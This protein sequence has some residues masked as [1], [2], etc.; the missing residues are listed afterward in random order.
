[1]KKLPTLHILNGDA[2]LP[3]I[4]AAKL[5]G[6]ILVWR[7]ILSEGPAIAGLPEEVFWQRRQMYMEETYGETAATYKLNVLDEL[8]KLEAAGSFF[9]VVLWFDADL[10]CQ[11]NLLYLLH[12]MHQLKPATVYVCTPPMPENISLLKKETLLN[13]YE[14]RQNQTIQQLKQAHDL[15]QLYAGTDPMAVQRYLQ[16]HQ[17]TV[18][19]HF[20]NALTLH[21]SRFPDCKNG[22]N[23]PENIL[24][25]FIQEG[26]TT[27][28]Q[29][30][31]QFWQQHPEYGFG[32]WQLLHI[33]K[34]MQPELVHAAVPLTIT[35]L[36]EQVLFNQSSFIT[37]EKY[38]GGYKID[39]TN[40]LCFNAVEQQLQ[41]YT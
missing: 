22:L 9:E 30:M 17:N 23:Q 4:K 18:Q 3:A 11:I 26:A 14:S 15:W 37:K 1:M 2:T 36:G 32:D 13:L 7:E 16:Q 5:P 39:A 38:M 31:Q 25:Q 27:K 40:M 33:L 28:E 24:L 8:Q 20:K 19:P 35:P 21:L 29:L 34:Q 12:R 10:M 41:I 6:Q